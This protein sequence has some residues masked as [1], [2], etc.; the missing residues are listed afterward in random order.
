M[1]SYRVVYSDPELVR[2]LQRLAEYAKGYV[3]A[4][5]AKLRDSVLAEAKGASL[6]EIYKHPRVY[7]RPNMD[8]GK[9]RRG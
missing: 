4:E 5:I 9:A 6:D 7:F 3:D 8:P 1:Y 2:K